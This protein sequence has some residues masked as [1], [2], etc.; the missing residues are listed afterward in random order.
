M[1]GTTHLAF[2]VA[3]GLALVE[4]GGLGMGPGVT[5]AHIGG[6]PVANL[7]PVDWLALAL[8]AGVAALLPD[9][10]QPGSMV[11]RLPARQARHVGRLLRG[12]HL[13]APAVIVECAGSLLAAL[14][15]GA[16]G[17]P[18]GAQRL[19]LVLLGA[20]CGAVAATA[21]WLPPTVL[22]TWPASLREMITVVLALLALGLLAIAAGGVAGLIHRLPGHHRGWTH[23]PAFAAPL[24]AVAIAAGP[25]LL[26]AL[27]GA[28][29]AFATGYLSHLAADACTI[30][31]I[32][33]VLP[34]EMRPSLHLLPRPLRVRTGSA[35]E[36]LFN[37]AWLL[38]LVV[39]LVL[40]AR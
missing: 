35:G 17:W 15:G 6:L 38:A 24:A 29:M 30:R 37:A 16:P 5:W 26:P 20:I 39:A 21:R 34:G 11:T 8:V 40:R 25:S 22:L 4:L 28:G 10:D 36:R 9:I 12:A 33:L 18:S 2:G 31:G 7:N 1:Q 32:P 23:A 3:A 13:A 14:L 19:L 27:P